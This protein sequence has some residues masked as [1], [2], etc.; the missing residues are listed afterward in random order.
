[1]GGRIRSDDKLLTWLS[2]NIYCCRGKSKSDVLLCF[3][4]KKP[5]QAI[6]SFKD[7]LL[8]SITLQTIVSSDSVSENHDDA[9]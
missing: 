3:T 1:M 7:S 9:F 2:K 4:T 8:T 5:L 6:V